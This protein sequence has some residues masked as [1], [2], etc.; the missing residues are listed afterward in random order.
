VGKRIKETHEIDWDTK[1]ATVEETVE[2]LQTCQQVLAQT[3]SKLCNEAD[4]KLPRAFVTN[5]VL[6]FAAMEQLFLH[7]GEQLAEKAQ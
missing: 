5:G 6:L 2:R 3:F 7:L 1:P 4:L